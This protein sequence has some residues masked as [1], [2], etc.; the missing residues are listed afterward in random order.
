MSGTYVL[1]P[2]GDSRFHWDL[3]SGNAQTVLSSQMYSSEAA[4]DKGI[5]SC[6]ENGPT[7]VT[8]DDTGK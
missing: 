7:A 2:A 8:Q 5:A 4:R 3:K 6:R 1:H